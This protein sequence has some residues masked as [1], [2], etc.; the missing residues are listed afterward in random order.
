MADEVEEAECPVG[1]LPPPRSERGTARVGEQEKEHAALERTERAVHGCGRERGQGE[2]TLPRLAHQFHLPPQR[3]GGTDGLRRPHRAGY[4]SDE[5]VPR[6]E[7]ELSLG[8]GITALLGLAARPPSGPG[9]V[10][11]ATLAIA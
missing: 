11:L 1:R 2:R 8:R 3:V 7:P 9:R 10:L 6:S 5:E 4:V